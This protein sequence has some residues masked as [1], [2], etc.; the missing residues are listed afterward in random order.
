MAKWPDVPDCF[1]WLALDARGQWWMR[2]ER[3]QALGSFQAGP[4]QARGSVLQ[5]DKL[6]GFIGR[7]YASDPQGRWYFQN[8]PQRVYVELAITP[9]IWRLNDAIEVTAHTGAVAQAHACLVDETGR[10][11]LATDLGFG[12]VHT[13]DVPRLAQALDQGIWTPEA[14]QANEL[15]QRFAYVLSPQAAQAQALAVA[16]QSGT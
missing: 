1:A 7:N 13:M 4:P 15:P 10:A 11:Y 14:C 16:T 9:Y 12:L 3:V 5:H 8:G 2:D 6:I